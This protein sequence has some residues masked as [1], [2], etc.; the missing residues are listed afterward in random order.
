MKM[1][2]RLKAR[3]EELKKAGINNFTI[4]KLIKPFLVRG[5]FKKSKSKTNKLDTWVQLYFKR[6][7]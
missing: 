5:H 2:P 4:S 3:K 1:S 6:S 7:K